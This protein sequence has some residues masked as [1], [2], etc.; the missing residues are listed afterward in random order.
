MSAEGDI[1]ATGVG[2]ISPIGFTADETFNNMTAG[3]TGIHEFDTGTEN[4][5][6]AGA[7]KDFDAEKH[8][9][10]KQRSRTARSTQLALVATEEAFRQAGVIFEG[11]MQLTPDE[12][13][14]TVIVVGTGYG[15]GNNILRTRDAIQGGKS[16]SAFDSTLTLPDNAV[17][18]ISIK[19]G[20]TGPSTAAVAACASGN[21]AT[22][23]AALYLDAGLAKRAVVVGT[24][25][26]LEREVFEGF[27]A[28]RRALAPKKIIKGGV[29]IEI[30]PEQASRPFDQNRLGFVVGEAAGVI[31]MEKEESAK[32]RGAKILARLAGFGHTSDAYHI[33]SPSVEGGKLAMVQALANSHMTPNQIDHIQ[34]HGTGTWGGDQ[35]EL[36]KVK[37]VFGE[38]VNKLVAEAIKS[39]H[40]HTLGAASIQSQ[41]VGMMAMNRQLIPPSLNIDNPMDGVTTQE[42]TPGLFF[43]RVAHHREINTVMT[44]GFGFGGKNAVVIWSRA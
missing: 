32:R 25:A 39:Q 34:M 30:L 10:R 33:T 36:Y 18:A 15:G 16:V 26:I 21:V 5:N 42:N 23:I 44:N 20:I 41:I 22:I 6:A 40:G 28:M 2:M 11:E 38:H 14:G 43:P 35:S 4:Y 8:F 31:F 3:Q 29:E 7:I 19:Y 13:L 27:G 12:L 37:E 17:G 1:V 9:D 24:D